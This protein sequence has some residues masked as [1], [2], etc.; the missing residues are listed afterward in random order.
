[1]TSILGQFKY[2][3]EYCYRARSEPTA[4]A[5]RTRQ[6]VMS[7]PLSQPAIRIAA[8]ARAAYRGL[9]NTRVTEEVRSCVFD[10]SASTTS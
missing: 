10:V 3:V 5:A 7:L 9:S 1:M 2:C 4:A 8:V 6:S